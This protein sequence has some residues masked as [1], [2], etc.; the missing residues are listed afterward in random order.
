MEPK[1]LVVHGPLG[2]KSHGHRKMQ[3]KRQLMSGYWMIPEVLCD[4]EEGGLFT[5][6]VVRG[7]HEE[8]VLL[9]ADP[10]G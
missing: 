10:E 9:E 7:G 1:S 6:G 5:G 2:M 8:E 3:T 4:I